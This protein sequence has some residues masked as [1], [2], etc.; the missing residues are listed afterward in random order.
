MPSS[1][2]V[3]CRGCCAFARPC[4]ATAARRGRC[5][6]NRARRRGGARERPARPGRSAP[7]RRAGS[8]D[9]GVAAHRRVR[10]RFQGRGFPATA[11]RAAGRPRDMAFAGSTVARGRGRRRGRRDG[12]RDGARRARRDHVRDGGA[13]SRRSSSAWR[14]QPR[15]RGRGAG[16]RHRHRCRGRAPARREPSAD[17]RVR[18]GAGGVR[19]PGGPARGPHVDARDRRPAHGSAR[20]DRAQPPRGGGARQL[21]ADRQRQDRHA[22]LQRTHGA[23]AA[24]RRRPGVRRHGAGYE[25]TGGIGRDRPTT[26]PRTRRCVSWG[27]CSRWPPPATRRNSSDPTVAGRRGDPTDVALLALARK[28]G[29]DR[30]RLVHGRPLAA[31]SR[32]SPSDGLPRLFTDAGGT[33][34]AVKGAP[35]SV[36]R[37]CRLATRTGPRR[38]RLPRTWRRAA[39]GCL[40][41]QR[42]A[43]G[44]AASGGHRELR[45]ISSSSAWSD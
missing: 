2:A 8:R 20:R 15:G 25:P 22:D 23:R 36:L 13:A 7:A 31:A 32:S 24:A 3:R 26:G 42:V 35:E 16:R 19:N 44:S 40:R 28:G 29:V 18:G 34:I 37:M 5:R 39:T 11:R 38:G 9:R 45:P 6:G 43:A 4:C 27:R 41:S 17:V 10:A 14:V 21:H 30:D 33:W 12:H 1:R